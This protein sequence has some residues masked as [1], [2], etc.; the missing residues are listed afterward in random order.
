MR[1]HCEINSQVM[2]IGE[3][4]SLASR[5]PGILLRSSGARC[6]YPRPRSWL[7]ALAELENGKRLFLM[8]DRVR[9]LRCELRQRPARPP[10]SARTCGCCRDNE[11]LQ[12]TDSIVYLTGR[13]AIATWSSTADGE[14]YASSNK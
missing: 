1:A 10:T 5:Q 14:A 7:M 9:A 3:A 12:R 6:E 11:H 4:V 13:R 2:A 8:R